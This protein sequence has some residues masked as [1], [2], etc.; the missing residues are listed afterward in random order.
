MSR[1]SKVYNLYLMALRSRVF[2]SPDVLQWKAWYY[3]KLAAPL[4]SHRKNSV[5]IPTLTLDSW[6][7]ASWAER[8]CWRQRWQHC[9]C[10][11]A[12]CW[13]WCPSSSPPRWVPSCFRWI[14]SRTGSSCERRGRCNVEIRYE[15]K[16]QSQKLG[17]TYLRSKPSLFHKFSMS[18]I[19]CS[20]NMSCRRSEGNE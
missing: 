14:N 20:V 18:W 10:C 1:L 9:C 15:R 2:F 8:P 5:R 19:I 3:A 7:W 6:I 4:S 11:F 17:L 13:R 12:G 16:S